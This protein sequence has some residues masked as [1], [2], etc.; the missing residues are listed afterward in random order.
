MIAEHSQVVLTAGSFTRSGMHQGGLDH[1]SS[2][3]TVAFFDSMPMV[4][5][6]GALTDPRRQSTPWEVDQPEVP[7][8]T[9][10]HPPCR[11]ST[12]PR[13]SPWSAWD[14]TKTLHG[15]SFALAPPSTITNPSHQALSYFLS[16][17]S[18][19][20]V[21]R[22]QRHLVRSEICGILVTSFDPSY[23]TESLRRCDSTGFPQSLRGPRWCGRL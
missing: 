23:G 11:S 7:S 9:S 1:Q 16:G 20:P 3:H 14:G 10:K 4:F 21:L 12:A 19:K 5:G 18:L 6:V 22:S 15:R 8:P 2:H 17:V 13:R